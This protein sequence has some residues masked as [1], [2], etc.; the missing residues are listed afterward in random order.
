M[1][2]YDFPRHLSD[3]IHRV[4]RVGRVGS[5][6]GSHVT[7]FVRAPWEV[8]LVRIIEVPYGYIELLNINHTVTHFY[9][10][11]VVTLCKFL[12]Q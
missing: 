3:Y 1:I 12:E 4:G 7:S 5:V 8:D 9:L 10:M 6:P 2:N 11:N